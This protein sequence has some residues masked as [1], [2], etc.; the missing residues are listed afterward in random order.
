MKKG[1][2]LMVSALV[3]LVLLMPAFAAPAQAAGDIKIGVIDMKKIMRESKA[4]KK[5]QNVFRKDLDAKRAV[6][7]AKEKEI[8]DM[9]EQ[10]KKDGDKM[11]AEA[12]QKAAVQLSKDAR[13]LKLTSG[14]MEEELKR[15]AR[16]MEQKIVSDVMKVVNA[17]TKKENYTLIL[18]RSTVL[19][20]NQALD[21]T[22]TI[23]K[24]YDAKK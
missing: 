19:D 10:F 13:E 21:I 12:R 9:E 7:A 22:D 11:T 3:A 18:E 4:A 17:Y 1:L 2:L 23:I 8:R 14:D 5:A 20:L 15:M 24:L 6:L 16:E